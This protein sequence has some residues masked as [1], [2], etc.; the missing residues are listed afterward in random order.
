MTNTKIEKDPIR[1]NHGS[2]R[3]PDLRMADFPNA[4]KIVQQNLID[5]PRSKDAVDIVLVNPPTPDG[6]L[7]IRTQHRVGRRTRENMVWPQVSLAQMGALLVPQYTIAIIDANAE[8][9]G[10]PEFAQ[11]LEKYQ[12]RYYLTQVTAPTL[13]NDMYGCFLAKLAARR[14]S[15]SARMSRRCHAR[16]CGPFRRWI[17]SCWAS[18]T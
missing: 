5:T 14:R 13:E 2:R 16:R 8:R 18:R 15:P 3:I 10:W 17:S 12:P 6:E 11:L 1:E 4:D 7:W 9:M